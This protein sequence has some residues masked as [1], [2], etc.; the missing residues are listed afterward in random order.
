MLVKDV[1]TRQPEWIGPE[2]TLLDAAK[3]MHDKRIGSLPVGENDRIIGM[4]PVCLARRITE[5]APT[6][7]SMRR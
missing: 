1:M 3:K 2:T 7:S 5:S 4:V 6:T